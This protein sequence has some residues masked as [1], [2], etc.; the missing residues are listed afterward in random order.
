MRLTDSY[1]LLLCSGSF[2]RIGHDKLGICRDGRHDEQNKEQDWLHWGIT[3]KYKK[4]EK[5]ATAPSLWRYVREGVGWVMIIHWSVRPQSCK[6]VLSSFIYSRARDE[7]SS[8]DVDNGA[9]DK[10]ATA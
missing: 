3:K 1:K 4:I 9:Q 6:A 10:L 2:G 7:A 8:A 5:Q